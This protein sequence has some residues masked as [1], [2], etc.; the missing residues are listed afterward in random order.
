[1]D[2]TRINTYVNYLTC[3][4]CKKSKL[5]RRAF[6]EMKLRGGLT[7]E[8]VSPAAFPPLLGGWHDIVVH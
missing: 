6:E 7:D 8:V 3:N 1:M 2:W 4:P 5:L